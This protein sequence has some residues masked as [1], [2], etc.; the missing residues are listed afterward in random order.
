MMAPGMA[1]PWE[2]LEAGVWGDRRGETLIFGTLM[3]VSM[4]LKPC[5][6]ANLVCLNRAICFV[7][8]IGEGD[9][10]VLVTVYQTSKAQQDL[11]AKGQAEINDRV[12]RLYGLTDEEQVIIE[13]KE[14]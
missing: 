11:D 10:N 9:H 2:D 6:L 4:F 12:A 7:R 5:L 8:I 13:G 3:A 14:G 1:C